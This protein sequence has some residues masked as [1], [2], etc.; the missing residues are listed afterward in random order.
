MVEGSATSW[1]T[2]HRDRIS[3]NLELALELVPKGRQ[4]CAVLK[5][6]AY[7]HGI[8]QVAPLIQEQGVTIIGFTSNAE[9]RAIREAGFKGT[10]IRLRAA[11]PQ[12]IEGALGDHVQEQVAS[13]ATA[14]QL[15]K[16]LDAGQLRT[17]AHLA[18]N[19]A[20]MSR[21]G[22]EISTENGQDVCRAILD[23]MG[24]D[25]CGICS[26]FP[27]NEPGQLRLSSAQFQRQAAFIFENSNLKRTETRVH[28]GS[29]LT[30]I[31][32]VDVQSDMY[33]C[34]AILYGILRPDLGFRPTM[35]LE[36]RV[37]S[38]QDYPQGVSVGYDRACRLERDCRLACISIGYE[39]GFR[40]VAHDNSVV[41]VRSTLAPV[42]GK[43]SM[44]AIVAD[45]TG[46]EDVEVGDTVG[47]FRDSEVAPILPHMAEV[48]FRTI[49]ADLYTDWGRRN[50]RVYR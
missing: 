18:L 3:R 22:L 31:S 40:R 7:G 24:G 19:A 8:A 12:E 15:R 10:M 2:V 38:L 41:A 25:I 32:D 39:N 30:L 11:T 47:V 9:A 49:M 23:I 1:C 14:R 6:D 21:E 13:V 26:H 36:A 43:I 28:A 16:H 50:H 44:N 42:L 17:G 35:D 27:S 29:S 4:F 46:I 20:G 45:V 48:Q 34:G 33:R 5:A 37:I